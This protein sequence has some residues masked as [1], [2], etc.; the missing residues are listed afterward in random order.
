[1]GLSMA[2]RERKHP[3]RPSFRKTKESKNKTNWEKRE[4]RVNL[5]CKGFLSFRIKVVEIFANRAVYMCR[6]QCPQPQRLMLL[7]EPDLNHHSFIGSFP[8]AVSR[9]SFKFF[10]DGKPSS[11]NIVIVTARS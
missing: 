9:L 8:Q 11:G 6:A 3:I 1:M 4:N 2:S 5:I 7:Y 10:S